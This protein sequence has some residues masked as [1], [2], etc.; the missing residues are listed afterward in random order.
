MNIRFFLICVVAVLMCSGASA[1]VKL[2]F[3]L[4]KAENAALCPTGSIVISCDANLS[5]EAANVCRKQP[6]AVTLGPGRAGGRCG[7]TVVSVQCSTPDPPLISKALLG[8]LGAVFG[9]TAA[10]YLSFAL[11][12]S[13]IELFTKVKYFSAIAML[14]DWVSILGGLIG[15]G[16][17]LWAAYEYFSSHTVVGVLDFFIGSAYAASP[18]DQAAVGWM[19]PYVAV[20]VLGLMAISFLVALGTLLVVKDTKENQA[21]IKA[22]DNIVKTFGGFFTGLATTLLK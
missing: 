17:A 5:S 13:R 15:L 7:A 2:N 14:P 18:N 16:T 19:L 12:S 21:R 11:G 3:T 8:L 4:C 6:E 20:L 1:E 10:A 9:A 22:A